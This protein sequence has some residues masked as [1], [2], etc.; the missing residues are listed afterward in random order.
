MSALVALL[1]SLA[2][3]SPSIEV[4]SNIADGR[5]LKPDEAIEL[6]LSR[7][8]GADND[9]RVAV[10]IGTTDWT[11]LFVHERSSV[12][13]YRGRPVPLP[14]G[15]TPFVVYQ[16]SPANEWLAVARW[17]LRVRSPAGFETSDTRPRIEIVNKG[18]VAQA[19]EPD[20][21]APPRGTFQDVALN[22]GLQTR[23]VRNGVA[24]ASQ[25]NFLGVSNQPEALR[26]GLEGAAA[27]KLDLS[28]YLARVE[29]RRGAVAI[30]HLALDAHRYLVSSFSSRGVSAS[31]KAARTE[32]T[33]AAISGNSIVGFD[34]LS[35][36]AN[37]DNRVALVTVSSDLFARPGASRIGVTF[38]AGSLLPR[39]GFTQGRIS[40][41]EHGRGLGL[42]FVG[43][44]P[45]S[46]GRVDAGVARTRFVNP[47]D[48][49]LAQGLTLVPMRERTNDAA[50][51]DATIGLV[52]GRALAGAP[53]NVAVTYRFERVE[54][55]YR[56]V[57]APLAVRSD[58]LVHTAELTGNWGALLGQ[59]SH[60][61]SHDNLGNVA[62]I[63]RT[64]T[65][66]ITS[67]VVLPIASFSKS[68]AAA[69]WLPV[70]SWTL[71]QSAQIGDGLPPNG[72][73]V[74]PSQIPDQAN[75]HHVARSEWTFARWRAGYSFGLSNV[76]NRQEGRSAADFET[77]TQLVSVGI[78]PAKQIDLG[79][80]AGADR[81]TN[82][83]FG[84][85]A[86]T[87]RLGLNVNWRPTPRSSLTGIFSRTSLLDPSAGNSDITDANLQYSH[88]MPLLPGRRGPEAR[89]FARWSWQSA[90]IIELLFGADQ[91]RRNWAISTGV[92][93]ALF[94]P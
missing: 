27:P 81:A 28:D 7:T 40:D 80:D 86:R 25:V 42:R 8:P 24:L 77:T 26:F 18:Q 19:H 76:D 94:R 83:E 56:T 75:V 23:H 48:P 78:A 54:P 6:R 88:A 37:S 29:G 5:W 58:V 31:L 45:G 89:L 65:R 68:G 22:L 74:S 52:K 17:T 4:T 1:S 44:T 46:R 11:G 36:L 70:V 32:V 39:S 85:V 50:Y 66:L 51:L 90:S 38:L 49:L 21:N 82:K 9:E 71:S 15:E 33:V 62:S 59:V 64:N 10:M 41:A 3:A 73:F 34:N 12:L 91:D 2:L 72:G 14:D 79:I 69:A 43:S 61:W 13:T 92:T 53:A 57:G 67:N 20:S 60:G 63:L 93:L 16:V 55:L 87:R 47:D 30:G 35:G 84:R